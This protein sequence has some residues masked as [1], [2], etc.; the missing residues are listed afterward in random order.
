[1][2]TTPDPRL[3]SIVM[4]S[5]NR[6]AMPLTVAAYSAMK[7]LKDHKANLFILDGGIAA[8][9]RRKICQSIDSNQFRI[10]WVRP[11]SARLEVIH[12]KSENRRFPLPAYFRLLLPEVLPQDIYKVIYLDTDTIVPERPGQT[13]GD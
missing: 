10:H 1:M 8:A 12:R 13:V 6:C 4:A 5:D 9:G 2:D 7:N 11:A 3:I